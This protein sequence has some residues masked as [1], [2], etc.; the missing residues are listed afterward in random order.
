MFSYPTITDPFC[1]ERSKDLPEPGCDKHRDLAEEAVEKSL[2]LV[3]NDND[4]LPLKKGTKVYITGPAADNEAAQ[5]G[6][7]TVAWQG[8]PHDDVDGATSILDG[9]RQKAEEYGLTVITDEEKAADADAVILAVGEKAYAEWYGDSENMD[10]CGDC[11]LEGNR[12]AID[13]VK[14]LGKPTVCCIVAGFPS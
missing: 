12:E 14:A 3:K 4:I 6:G 11:G 10:L 2:V 7:W 5:C 9:L 1:G 8:S 13:K